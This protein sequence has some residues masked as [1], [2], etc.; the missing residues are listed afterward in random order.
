MR[1]RCINVLPIAPL[2]LLKN[3]ARV[4]VIFEGAA[5]LLPV[6]IEG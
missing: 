2:S 1:R 4:V 3:N 5:T 6:W